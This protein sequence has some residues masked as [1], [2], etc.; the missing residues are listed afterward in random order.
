MSTGRLSACGRRST[1]FCTVIVI[2]RDSDSLDVHSLSDD[3]FFPL[4]TWRLAW[5][6]VVQ[7]YKLILVAFIY[8]RGDGR[9][10]GEGVAVFHR[11][12]RPW[13]IGRLKKQGLKHQA[14]SPPMVDVGYFSCFVRSYFSPCTQTFFT[15]IVRAAPPRTDPGPTDPARRDFVQRGEMEA[16]FQVAHC[17]KSFGGRKYHEAHR[18]ALEARCCPAGPPSGVPGPMATRTT[19]TLRS[20]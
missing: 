4:L 12:V 14:T 8:R 3:C 13:P 15:R 19:C 20:A 17:H 16:Y 6:D 5:C 9:W 11:P 10:P 18:R 1:R 2:G 7:E